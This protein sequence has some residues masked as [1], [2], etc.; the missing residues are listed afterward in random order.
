M[1]AKRVLIVGG[2]AGG[3]ACAARLRRLDE[4]ARNLPLRARAL[5]SRS[6]IAACPITW[7]A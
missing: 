3:A 6:P 5:R 1:A 2:V 4:Q 7:A